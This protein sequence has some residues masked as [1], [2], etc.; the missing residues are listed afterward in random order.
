MICLVV[1]LLV[2]VDIRP[3]EHL[4]HHLGVTCEAKEYTPARERGGLLAVLVVRAERDRAAPRR[5]VDPFLHVE[6]RARAVGQFFSLHA[7]HREYRYLVEKGL[8]YER[9]PWWLAPRLTATGRDC[10]AHKGGNVHEQLNPQPTNGPTVNFNG[11]NSGNVA[12]GR[13]VTQSTNPVTVPGP[14]ENTPAATAT[15]S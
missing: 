3:G 6:D 2:H 7:V 1:R 9:S 5:L 14:A 12:I 8:V 13:D 15:S 11:N 4:G 10:A